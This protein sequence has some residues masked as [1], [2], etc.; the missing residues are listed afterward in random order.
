MK[1]RIIN[2]IMAL[3][4]FLTLNVACQTEDLLIPGSDMAPE[5]YMNLR[6]NV[7]VPDMSRV[8]TKA[9]DPDGGGVQQISVFCF[10]RNDLFITVTTAK[11][12]ADSGNPSLSGTFETSVPEHTVTLQLVGNQNLT[13]FKEENYR[14]MS[15]VDVMTA[16]EASAGRMIYWSRKTVEEISSYNS[17]SNPII[18]RK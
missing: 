5:G 17:T 6:F 14:G 18:Y 10:D 7:E 13:Y 3:A 12:I 4:G 2:T 15:E 1:T 16:I 11:V 9:V 8:S